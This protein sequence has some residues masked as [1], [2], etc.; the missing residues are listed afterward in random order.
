MGGPWF[1][2][3]KHNGDWKLVDNIWISNGEAGCKAR[4]ELRVKLAE[5]EPTH[6]Q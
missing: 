6:D 3:H 4:V 1:T 2:V 5:P